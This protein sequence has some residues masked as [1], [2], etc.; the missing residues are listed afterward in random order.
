MSFEGSATISTK[1]QRYGI[2][3]ATSFSQD[4]S[5][6]SAAKSGTPSRIAIFAAKMPNSSVNSLCGAVAG[7]AAGIVT[8]PLDVIKTKLQA[9]G[10]FRPRSSNMMSNA[11][12]PYRGMIGTAKIIW[13]QD[14]FRGMYRGLGP[15]LFGYLPTWAVYMSVYGSSREYYY[16]KVGKSSRNGS[17]DM[18]AIYR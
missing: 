17:F 12:A 8:C 15:M 16:G 14:G 2:Q 18:H 6:P 9:Q 13:Q 4:A 3:A 11:V 7:A 10:G 1:Q 5:N